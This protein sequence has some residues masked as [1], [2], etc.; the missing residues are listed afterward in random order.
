MQQQGAIVQYHDPHVPL[1][2]G[3][4]RYLHLKLQSV[5]LDEAVV[6]HSD[7]TL[8][9][10]DH[11]AVNYSLVAAHSALIIDTRNALAS[12]GIQGHQVIKA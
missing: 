1:C 2:Q 7:A 11:D 6:S 12:R 8:I 3:H 10:T 9:V 4:S 5:P